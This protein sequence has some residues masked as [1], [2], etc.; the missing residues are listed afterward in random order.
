[1]KV[2]IFFTPSAIR[3]LKSLG[4]TSVGWPRTTKSLEF[5]FLRLVSKSSRDSSKN[6]T[7]LDSKAKTR[8]MLFC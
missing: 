8:D 1:M 4:N 6:L 5:S 3:T 2:D 7:E